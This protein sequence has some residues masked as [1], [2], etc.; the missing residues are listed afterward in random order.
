[1][2]LPGKSDVVRAGFLHVDVDD[3]DALD[4]IKRFAPRPTAVVFSGGG[5]QAFWKLSEPSTD[6]VRVE[7]CNAALARELGRDKC[8]NVDRIMRVL[9][10]INVPTRT[11]RH[12]GRTPVL[13]YLV[14]GLTDW[15]REYPLDTFPEGPTSPDATPAAGVAVAAIPEVDLETLPSLVHEPTKVL[16]LVGDDPEKPIGSPSARYRSR[17]EVVYRVACDLVRAECPDEVIAGILLD[18]RFGISASMREKSNPKRYAERQIASA[19]EAVSNGWPDVTGGGRPRATLRNTIV[20]VRRLGISG[21]YDEFHKRKILGGHSLQEYEGELSD[22]GCTALRVLILERFGFDPRA[23]NTRDAVN[24]ICIAN[25]H[26]PVRDYLRGLVWDGQP[27]IDTWLTR[28]LGADA[29]P[30]TC[31]IGRI[32]LLAAA[33]QEGSRRRCKRNARCD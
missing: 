24:A 14:E 12:K 3:L 1:M 15:S 30:L 16:I 21:E 2:P 7:R 9:G 6:L 33:R 26:H 17:S 23:D 5:Y 28:Y 20:A 19:K 11:K 10:T 13:A 22:D 32:V 27:R 18:P 8:H 4:A 25:A 31:A 29:S